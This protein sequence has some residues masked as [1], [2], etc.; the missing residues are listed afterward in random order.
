MIPAV[1]LSLEWFKER[2]GLAMGFFYATQILVE[3]CGLLFWEL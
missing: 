2:R 1:P 3:L